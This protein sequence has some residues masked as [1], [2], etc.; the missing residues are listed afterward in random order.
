MHERSPKNRS[1]E[2]QRE[3]IVLRKHFIK[4]GAAVLMLT[5]SSIA[6]R[7]ENPSAPTP[8]PQ[9]KPQ[10][11]KMDVA[12]DSSVLGVPEAPIRIRRPAPLAPIQDDTK[13]P[14]V[15]NDKPLSRAETKKPANQLDT[16]KPLTQTTIKPAN[17]KPISPQAEHRIPA[18]SKESKSAPLKAPART[19]AILTAGAAAYERAK[20]L[21]RH[22]LYKDAIE[23]YTRASNDDPKN[24][25][26]YNRRARAEWQMEQLKEALEDAN[27]AIKSNPDYA[28]AFCTRAAIYNSMGNY[29]EAIADASMARDLKPSLRE[30]YLIQT[31]AYH[32]LG[33]HTE[34]DAVSAKLNE[35]QN[36]QSAF[37]EWQPNIDFTPYFNYLQTTVRQNWHAPDGTYGVAVVLFKV[38]RNGTVSDIRLNN[39]TG[40]TRADTTAVEAVK[41]CAPFR[42]PPAGSPPD[43]DVYVVMDRPFRSPSNQQASAPPPPTNPTPSGRSVN[44][45]GALNQ[46]LG[47]MQ[48]ALQFV[49]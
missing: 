20:N 15:Q 32:N 44:W 11:A 37:D 8:I 3:L 17:A 38:H 16:K 2:A 24:V 26:I 27:W 41:T 46:G 18:V 9:L 47:I 6:A 29:Q 31:I 21:S 23:F 10:S 34:A 5:F 39:T 35:M 22:G 12:K 14:T 7:A 13:K 4:H 30:A 28:E 49:R 42:Q 33:Q 36:L 25:E 48:R 1:V 45:G 43:F 19:G 40:D